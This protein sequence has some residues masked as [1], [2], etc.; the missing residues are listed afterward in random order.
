MHFIISFKKTSLL[1]EYTQKY[2]I[3][4]K[5]IKNFKIYNFV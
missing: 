4:L 2:K 1:D 3:F 5:E